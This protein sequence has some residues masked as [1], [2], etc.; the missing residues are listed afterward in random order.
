MGE[1]PSVSIIVPVY[2]MEHYL[3]RC[4]RSLLAQTFQDIEILLID[5][6]STDSSAE[7]CDCFAC[8]DQR[9]RVFHQPNGGVASARRYGIKQARGI[10]SIHADADDW[11]EP[12]M[13]AEMYE[14]IRNSQAD[15]L[16]ADFYSDL[17]N[18]TTIREDQSLI[19]QD[20]VSI[21]RSILKG[22]RFG[23]LWHKLL[24]HSLYNEYN[25]TIKDGIDY[26]EDVLILSQLLQNPLH[27][28]YINRAF[29]HYDMSNTQSITRNY[30]SHTYQ[31]KKRYHQQLTNILG[32]GNWGG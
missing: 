10:Y 11:V 1:S 20:S 29:Y 7:I 21:L 6:G 31:M 13:V 25:V 27:V 18:G 17:P 9:I 16:I 26:C 28:S 19:G 8:Q 32:P 24:R 22:D 14:T 15:M 30:T 4:V 12:D 5:D 2:N 3:E 23:S